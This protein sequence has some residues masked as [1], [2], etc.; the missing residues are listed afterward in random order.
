MSGVC[1]TTTIYAALIWF[2]LPFFFLI[3][4]ELAYGERESRGRVVGHESICSCRASFVVKSDEAIG[5]IRRR[6]NHRSLGANS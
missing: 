2:L 3:D 5:E 4:S 6:Q 1:T